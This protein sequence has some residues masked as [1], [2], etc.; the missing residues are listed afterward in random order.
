MAVFRANVILGFLGG[1][2]I[3]GVSVV[4]QGCLI[5]EIKTFEVAFHRRVVHKFEF[6]I[7]LKI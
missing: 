2:E 5:G 1:I 6:L 3:T 7:Y 4:P